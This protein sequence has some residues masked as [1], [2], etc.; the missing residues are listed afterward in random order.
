VYGL[1][2]AKGLK[3]ARQQLGRRNAAA[4]CQ[5][6]LWSPWLKTC[7][8]RTSFFVSFVQFFSTARYLFADA[9]IGKKGGVPSKHPYTSTWIE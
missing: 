6:P 9:L 3:V 5:L 7:V 1:T 8:V 2:Q 4:S